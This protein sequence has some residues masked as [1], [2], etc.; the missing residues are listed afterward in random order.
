MKRLTCWL[1]GHQFEVWQHFSRSTRRV[2]CHRCGGS[3]GMHDGMQA[4]VPW[5]AEIEEIYT[6]MGHRVRPMPRATSTVNAGE[7]AK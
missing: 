6:L 2:I 4:F 3:W 7:V 5:D 1:F